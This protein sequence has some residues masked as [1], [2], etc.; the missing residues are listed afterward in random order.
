MNHRILIK[1]SK[2]PI[3]WDQNVLF[4]VQNRP[5]IKDQELRVPVTTTFSESPNPGL[6]PGKRIFVL[7]C[8]KFELF[9]F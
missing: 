6:T 3:S 7:A 8:L 5:T 2:N 4:K 9:Q 1:L